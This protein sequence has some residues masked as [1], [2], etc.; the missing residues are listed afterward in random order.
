MSSV[1]LPTNNFSLASANSSIG[2]KKRSANDLGPQTPGG[3]LSPVLKKNKK[4]AE[5]KVQSLPSIDFQKLAQKMT[6]AT[7]LTEKA[8]AIIP[9][10][11]QNERSSVMTTLIEIAK[12]QAVSSGSRWTKGESNGIGR[13]FSTLIIDENLAY[14]ELKSKREIAKEGRNKKFYPTLE[15]KNNEVR[16][17]GES[18]V[19]NREEFEQHYKLNQID[20]KSPHV[21]PPIE[22][23][24]SH[25]NKIVAI[26]PL[27]DGA[28]Y[29]LSKKNK[30]DVATRAKVMKGA[31]EGLQAIHKNGYVHRDFNPN[32]IFVKLQDGLIV[33]GDM[34]QIT[35]EG[36][37]AE[38]TGTPGFIAPEIFEGSKPM[39]CSDVFAFGKSLE[40]MFELELMIDSSSKQTIKLKELIDACVAEDPANRPTMDQVILSLS[41]IF[42]EKTSQAQVTEVQQSPVKDDISSWGENMKQILG[43]TDLTDQSSPLCSLLNSAINEDA[44]SAARP[45]SVSEA[46]SRFEKILATF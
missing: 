24:H 32:N 15:V 2:N 14:M 13:T 10:S 25:G 37:N 38:F 27:Y 33:V 46:Q 30:W 42:P 12:G 35:K 4:D 43:L 34:D 8:M 26:V 3:N 36:E 9:S 23:L 45:K 22:I 19:M 17:V 41:E 6:Q 7:E 18:K 31:A 44:S 29:D 1:N 20:F 21:Q 16:L 28:A 5:V 39:A 40:L 11:F